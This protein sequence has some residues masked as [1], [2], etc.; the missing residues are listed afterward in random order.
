MAST[1]RGG[2][3]ERMLRV[4]SFVVL[5]S[6]I[7]SSSIASLDTPK[8]PGESVPGE[9]V[10][11]LK[12][13]VASRDLNGLSRRLG[14]KIV[15]RIRPD[16][17]VLKKDR[18][19]SSETVLR[20]LRKLPDVELIE[21]NY[22]ITAQAL[23]NDPQLSVVWGMKN[24]RS[25]DKDGLRGVD[26][27]DVSAERAWDITTGSR[28]VIVAV[29]DTGVDY[30]HPDL[31]DNMWV[32]EAELNGEPGK[33][34]DGNG[35]VD[36]VYGYNVFDDNGDPR[37][38]NG[39][40]THCAGTIGAK[41]DNGI[42]I[43]GLNWNV[44]LMA[45]K[46]MNRYGYGTL[47]GAVR[48]IDYAQKNGARVL[49]NS[50][51]WPQGSEILRRIVSETQQRGILFVAAAGNMG[52]NSDAGYVLYPANLPLDNIISVGAVNNRG[53]L[54]SFSNYGRNRV[55]IV[56]PG[57]SVFSTSL[58]G[59]YASLSGTSM[60]VPYV[61]GTAALIWS[62]YPDLDYLEVRR[63]IL[64]TARPLW[65]VKDLVTAGGIV[66]A[67]H[68]LV[69]RTPY[70][71]DPNDPRFWIK[72]VEYKLSSDHPYKNEA[73]VKYTI[74]VPG[75]KRLAVHFS[76]FVTEWKY[77]YV[78]FYNEKDEW[79]GS[80]S[81]E[82]SG[83]FGPISDGETVHLKLKTDESKQYYGFD[84]DYIAVEY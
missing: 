22:Y 55:H 56:A 7:S 80:Y 39:H 63:R 5:L 81:G 69:N 37:D 24:Q 61:A 13:T 32:N 6:F 83:E 82:R 42:G 9:Y 48:A 67:Y 17:V 34:D 14:G 64:T 26:G 25:I 66:D 33:D 53:D 10:V 23:P 36:D 75:A 50:Y 19:E 47:E 51:G 72:R 11:L 40:G 57:V 16:M 65:Q 38:E 43:A 76:R 8:P 62:K 30:K 74:T 18:F 4:L 68:A 12:D 84:I 35:Y 70:L 52:A 15:R 20:N 29:I 2:R 31:A 77:D 79:L 78:A 21:P 27:V 49:S 59:G 60:A 46:F 41:G 73:E 45:V 71:R 44:R 54:A 1:S 3:M 58:N 28:E